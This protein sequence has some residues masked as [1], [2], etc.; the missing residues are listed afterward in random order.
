[1]T[2]FPASLKAAR[3]V[4]GDDWF[5]ERMK[6]LCVLDGKT[7]SDRLAYMVAYSLADEIDVDDD[8]AVE[9]GRVTDNKLKSAITTQSKKLE[10]ETVTEP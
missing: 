10:P 9:T 4:N 6:V 2:D 3:A 1:M 7:F 5:I 8:Y